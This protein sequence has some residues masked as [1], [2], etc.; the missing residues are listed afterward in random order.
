MRGAAIMLPSCS[1]IPDVRLAAAA[2]LRA[3]AA[4]QA[5][6]PQAAQWD[7]AGS[8]DCDIWVAAEGARICGFVIVRTVAQEEHEILNLAVA[9]ECRRR[10]IASVL[11]KTILAR[12]LGAVFL[13]VRESN[14]D[15]QR[16]YN[17]IGF[18]ELARRD[19]YY[20][21]PP[22]AAIVMKFHSC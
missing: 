14:R 6:S 10:G 8:P 15:A 3:I 9:P 12:H 17:S 20:E 4:I 18:Q 11:V 13:E 1:A 7:P 19:Q 22:E 2:D 21:C 16:F 5:A